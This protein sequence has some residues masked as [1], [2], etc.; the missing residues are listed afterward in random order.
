MYSRNWRTPDFALSVSEHLAGFRVGIDNPVMP[1][2]E[3]EDAVVSV[4]KNGVEVQ[5]SL[6]D[7]YAALALYLC[8]AQNKS[9]SDLTVEMAYKLRQYIYQTYDDYKGV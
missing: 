8:F 6:A 7:F 5:L 3:D 4:V 2:V 9:P 1:G